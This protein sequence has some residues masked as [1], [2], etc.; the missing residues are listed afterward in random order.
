MKITFIG[1][2][3]ACASGGRNQT[4]FLIEDEKKVFLLDC[5]P[6]SLAALT[7]AGYDT[8]EIDFILNT[9][10]HGDH[11]GGIPYFLMEQQIN[12]KREKDLNIY[13]PDKIGERIREL[14]EI[15]YPGYDL[16]DLD[17]KINFFNLAP[18]TVGNF[19][20]YE[21]QAFAMEHKAYS[22]CLGYRI[23]NGKKSFAYTGDTAWTEKIFDLAGDTDL[24]ICECSLMV[25]DPKL[26][27]VSYDQLQQNRDKIKTKRLILTHLSPPMLNNL[28]NI[29]VETAYDGLIVSL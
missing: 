23:S 8:S 15:L 28:A 11:F 25:K 18:G 24:F 16:D 29:E 12:I 13:G 27:H 21:V 9:H 17:Y 2:G 10:M 5:G 22:D 7:K 4:C 19:E 14:S 20:G 6:A 26:S 3:D 1:S